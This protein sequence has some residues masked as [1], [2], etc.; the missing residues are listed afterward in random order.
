LYQDAGTSAAAVERLGSAASE[1]LNHMSSLATSML[2]EAG[3]EMLDALVDSCVARINIAGEVNVEEF[4]ANLIGQGYCSPVAQAMVRSWQGA[5]STWGEL[6][7]PPFANG[8]TRQRMASLKDHMDKH[9]PALFAQALLRDL[10]SH[11][12]VRQLAAMQE[13]RHDEVLHALFQIQCDQVRQLCA[14]LLAPPPS[15]TTGAR[16]GVGATQ[17]G[18]LT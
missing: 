15:G 11:A 17:T 9:A 10:A 16:D 2:A 7:M 3:S 6:P 1:Q 4:M 8:T 5:M 18:Q 12:P 14:Q 13:N